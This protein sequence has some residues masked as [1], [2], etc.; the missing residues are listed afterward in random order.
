[1][2]PLRLGL[3]ATLLVTSSATAAP[4][5]LTFADF[6][7]FAGVTRTDTAATITTKW[8]KPTKDATAAG[9]R[10]LR[11][12]DGP[13]VTLRESGGIMVDLS[14]MAEPFAKAHPD[15]ATSLLGQ[16]CAAAGARLAFF[17]GKVPGYLTCKHYDKNGY[18]LDVTLMCTKTVGTVVVVWEPLPPEIKAAPLPKDH[19]NV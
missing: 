15:A 9:E 6:W 13:T 12:Q 1:M 19:C 18:F 2:S 16:T 11:Y 4:T 7:S 3:F 17:K 10:T 8:G 14:F 5:K